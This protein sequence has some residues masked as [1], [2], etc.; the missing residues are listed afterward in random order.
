MTCPVCGLE[1]CVEP[2]FSR[3]CEIAAMPRGQRREIFESDDVCGIPGDDAPDRTFVRCVLPV[4]LNEPGASYSW[5]LWVEVDDATAERMAELD[6]EPDQHEEPPFRATLANRVHGYPDTLGLPVWVQLQSP[7][8]R[9]VLRFADGL[10]HPFAHD[11]TRGVS[12]ARAH[13]WL[14]AMP[15]KRGW[16]SR[17]FG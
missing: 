7:T 6:E 5:G 9:P 3:P 13:E 2:A 15:R 4:R 8:Q 17:L 1:E 12:L 14:P 16:L 11:C 10:D